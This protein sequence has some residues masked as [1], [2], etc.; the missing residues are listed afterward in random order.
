MKA[1]LRVGIFLKAIDDETRRQIGTNAGARVEAVVQGS[2]AFDADV[3]AGDILLAVGDEKVV[4]PQSFSQMLEGH[5]GQTVVFHFYRDGRPI[6][7]SI[8]VRGF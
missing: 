7:K 4:A 8:A 5:A 2:P 6:D 1:K 3:F